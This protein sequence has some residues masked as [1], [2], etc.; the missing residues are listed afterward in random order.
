MMGG[1][2]DMVVI[3]VP[4]ALPQI[5]A[6]RVRAIA[7]VA[8]ARLPSLPEV[9]TGREAGL[10]DFE[11]QTWYGML[12]PGVTPRDIITR[13]NAEL[14]KALGSADLREKLQSV[15]FEPTSSTPEQF[16]DYLKVETVRWAKVIKD[17]KLQVE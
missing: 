6:G 15:G 1:Q 4:A 13:L 2:V 12:A 10:A 16:A 11:V 3:G 17:A 8:P 14:V 9:P 7:V 5:K